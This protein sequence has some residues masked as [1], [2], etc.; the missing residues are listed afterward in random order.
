MTAIGYCRVSSDD[1]SLDIQREQLQAAGCRRIFEEKIS[2]KDANRPELQACLKFLAK[3]DKLVVCKLDRLARS[4]LDMLTIVSDLG[5]RGV[6]FASLAE[7]WAN[8][9]TPA[10]ELILTLMAGVAQFE[11]GRIRERQID[12]IARAKRQGKY[13][14]RKRRITAAVV[15]EMKAKGMGV[16]AIAR[17]LNCTRRSIYL[18]SR[19]DAAT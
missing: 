11:R 3:D 8:T 4:T 15:Q 16:S 19:G 17:E 13:R 9:D 5:K 14:G 7:P 12:G 18:V 2:G 6:K 1:Q 10:A